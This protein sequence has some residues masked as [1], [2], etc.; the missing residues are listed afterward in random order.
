M[1]RTA[2]ALF[3]AAAIVPAAGLFDYDTRRALDIRV[4]GSEKRDGVEVRDIT[5]ASAGGARTPA[6][7]IVPPKSASHPAILF[8]HWY[9]PESPD[10]NRTQFIAEAVELAERGVVSLLPATMWS[11][12][13]WFPS[14]KRADDLENSAAQVKELRRALDVLLSHPGIDKSRVA[15]VGHDFGAMFGPSWPVRIAG[16]KPMPCRPAHRHSATGIYTD[17]RCRSRSGPGL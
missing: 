13:K 5:F 2:L 3:A 14:R 12:P 10:S 15:Y 4:T 16:P 11:E 8:V 9:E 6:Y 1:T 7:L 17:P